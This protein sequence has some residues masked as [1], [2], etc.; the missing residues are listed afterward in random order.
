MVMF[1]Q[2]KPTHLVRSGLVATLPKAIAD[3]GYATTFSLSQ[4]INV[5][6]FVNLY[7]QY[8]L[9]RVEYIFELATPFLSGILYPR[10]AAAVDLNDSTVPLTESEV[11][12][13]S[14]SRIF[15]FSP[16]NTVIGFSW[17][18]ALAT[19]Q[20]QGVST[21]YA[22]SSAKMWVDINSPA[23]TYYGIKF[24][25]SNYNT[26]ISTLPIITVVARYHL[27]FKTTK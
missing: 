4:V 2:P 27:S 19:A 3:F 5:S 20:F 11:I 10:L 25:L 22:Q 13:R 18:P 17:K 12:E 7:E 26:T 1:R 21:A 8:S 23:A 6:D 24:F 9:N 15:Q 14:N 16:D